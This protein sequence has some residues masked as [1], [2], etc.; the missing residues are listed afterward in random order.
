MHM[1]HR[2]GLQ[3][4]PFGRTSTCPSMVIATTM[5]TAI[6]TPALA[7]PV[8]TSMTITHTLLT[9]LV[10]RPMSQPLT[11]IAMPSTSMTTG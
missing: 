6:A 5:T 8:A 3:G 10:P 2:P 4:M 9:E 1:T 11:T 7:F